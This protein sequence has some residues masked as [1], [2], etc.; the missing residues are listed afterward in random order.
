MAREA[1]RGVLLSRVEDPGD[2]RRLQQVFEVE[3]QRAM[4]LMH[5]LQRQMQC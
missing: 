1:E 4:G 5:Q 3:R 2:R